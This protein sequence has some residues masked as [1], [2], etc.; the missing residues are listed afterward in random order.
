M[1]PRMLTAVGLILTSFL[2]HGVGNS[3]TATMTFDALMSL[4]EES[5]AA[6][7]RGYE[8]TETMTL[9]VDGDERYRV[10]HTCRYDA[11]GEVQRI[12]VAP[13]AEQKKNSLLEMQNVDEIMVSLKDAMALL[14]DYASFDPVKIRAAKDAGNVTV[15]APDKEGTTRVAIK[16]YLKPGDQVTIDV[17]Q[18]KGM[19]KGG[20]ISTYRGDVATN[21]KNSVKI[22]VDASAHSDGTP[23]QRLS[24]IDLVAPALQ[25][26]I[27]KSEYKKHQN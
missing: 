2:L 6:N 12:P 17:A 15:S 25:V 19:L 9:S 24:T 13:D 7:E 18:A 23:H 16:N 27:K 20:S 5:R 26:E 10:Q 11:D 14:S 1:K 22:R 3:A 8:W 4:I 21:D